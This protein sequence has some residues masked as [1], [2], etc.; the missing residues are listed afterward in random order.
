MRYSGRNEFCGQVSLGNKAYFA[1]FLENFSPHE[2]NKGSDKS[3]SQETDNFVKSVLHKL[4]R[5]RI[6][7]SI[8]TMKSQIREFCFA[9]QL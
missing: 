5:P 7:F 1:Y 9:W 8:V 3:C 2:Y 4:I 6:L